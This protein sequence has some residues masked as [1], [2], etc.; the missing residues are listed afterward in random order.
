MKRRLIIVAGFL[1]GTGVANAA[2]DNAAGQALMDKNGCSGCHE[3][4]RKV[5]GPAYKDV[6]ARY[7]GDKGAAARL[8][9]KVKKGGVHVWGEQAM[10]PNVLAS[11][12][13]VRELVDWI[14]TLN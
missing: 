6:A 14:L 5:V 3:I 12:A 4:D 7:R 1:L 9:D 11:D 2:I 10:P 8:R 13:D